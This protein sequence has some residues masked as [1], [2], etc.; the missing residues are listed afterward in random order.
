MEPDEA[1]RLIAHHSLGEGGPQVWADL[2]C[3]DGRFTRALASLLPDGSTIHA[4]DRDRAVLKSI[5]RSH[6]G[7][8]IQT[9]VGDFTSLPWPFEAVDGI[10]M[11]NSLHYVHDPLEFLRRAVGSMRRRHFL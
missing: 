8:D 2:G 1:R 7:V 6:H 10:L 5:E 9:H 3:G 4:I 11:A